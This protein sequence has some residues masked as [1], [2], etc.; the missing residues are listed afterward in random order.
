MLR[1]LASGRLEGAK[2]VPSRRTDARCERTCST[3]EH[4]R[5]PLT[6]VRCIL[7]PVWTAHFAS[8]ESPLPLLARPSVH[9]AISDFPPPAPLITS[10]PPGRSPPSRRCSRPLPLRRTRHSFDILAAACTTS[11]CKHE[12]YNHSLRH[13]SH[14]RHRSGRCA[15]RLERSTH[16]SRSSSPCTPQ[17]LPQRAA[18]WCRWYVELCPSSLTMTRYTRLPRVTQHVCA[19][20][21]RVEP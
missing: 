13:C 12:V 19:C 16:G 21:D 9:L 5:Q 2:P 20:W 11:F 15:Q 10:P 3:G 17:A 7:D 14:R 6:D 18:H 4:P 8:A 1:H